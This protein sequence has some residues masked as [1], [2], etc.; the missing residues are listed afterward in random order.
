MYTVSNSYAKQ[1]DD[2]ARE[3]IELLVPFFKKTADYV[4]FFF[5]IVSSRGKY[6]GV[7]YV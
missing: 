7:I 3:V 6:L 2:D 4:F 5:A 1:P